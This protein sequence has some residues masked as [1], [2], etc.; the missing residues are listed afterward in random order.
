M[1]RFHGPDI[2]AHRNRDV[3]RSVCLFAYL[4]IMRLKLLQF[5]D[6]IEA[7]RHGEG[8]RGMQMQMYVNV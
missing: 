7:I 1:R 6:V 8:Y 2:W 5:P 3:G 4:Q